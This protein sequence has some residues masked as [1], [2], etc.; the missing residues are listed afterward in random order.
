MAQMKVPT[1]ENRQLNEWQ[2]FCRTTL[3]PSFAFQPW[4]HRFAMVTER[5]NP[6]DAGNY[7]LRTGWYFRVK[8]DDGRDCQTFYPPWWKTRYGFVKVSKLLFNARP[9]TVDIFCQYSRHA[10]SEDSVRIRIAR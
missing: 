5:I 9:S 8:L 1:I 4:H 6:S 7:G 10:N 3:L 2:K